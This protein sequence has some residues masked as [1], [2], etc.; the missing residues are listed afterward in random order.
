MGERKGER[1]GEKERGRERG[2][3]EEKGGERRKGSLVVCLGRRNAY[4][5][6]KESHEHTVKS[7]RIICLMKMH[8]GS[9]PGTSSRKCSMTPIYFA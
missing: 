8:P 3:G 1:E 7:A 9:G 5:H 2:R 4:V 6:T